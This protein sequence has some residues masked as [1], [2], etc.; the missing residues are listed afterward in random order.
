MN[1]A[2]APA[3][4]GKL[5][6]TLVGI[7]LFFFAGI[8]PTLSWIEFSNGIETLNV[9]TVLEMRRGGPWVV[10]TL[11]EK[12]RINKPPLTAWFT[13]T[14]VSPQ[15]VAALST[16]DPVARDDAY[17]QLAWEI[18]WP[19]LLL[20]CLTLGL[21][22][23]MGRL[24]AG[25]RIGV[26]AAFVAGSTF[27]FLRFGRLATLDVQL[28]FW[29]MLANVLLLHGLLRG[30][31]WLACTGSGFC[32]GMAFMAKGP[33]ALAMSVAP[34]VVASL[35]VR[36]WPRVERADDVALSD[37]PSI[38]RRL[39]IA[40]VVVGVVC[41]LAVA[42]P[43]F[44][45]VLNANPNIADAWRREVTRVGASNLEADPFYNHLGGPVYM[46][47][48]FIFFF[49]GLMMVGLSAWRGGRNAIILLSF[50]VVPII[51]L[52]FAKDKPIRYLQPLLAPASVLA[53][54]ALVGQLVPW[55]QRATIDRWLAIVHWVGLYI[56]V[57]AVPVA[58]VYFLK[59]F[60][61]EPWFSMSTAIISAVAGLV[62]LSVF[63]WLSR[64]NGSLIAVG[65]VVVML[66]VNA[67]VLVGYGRSQG[68][69]A[70][71]RPIADYL[72]ST[73]I[74]GVVVWRDGRTRPPPMDL[75]IYLNRV[76]PIVDSLDNAQRAVVMR[77]S[78]GT[79][80]AEIPNWMVEKSWETSP[81]RKW[82]L[83]RRTNDVT[84]V[85]ATGRS[86]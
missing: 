22:F 43:W 11:A 80:T 32:L 56:A 19:S 61:G 48:W 9:E 34:M 3:S 49:V 58:G 25:F 39:P 57:V 77:R 10:P 68:G 78:G 79:N 35:I 67:L 82:E 55:A 76:L 46:L 47:P 74:D 72:H 44:I 2:R 18:R 14:F 42:L 26:M 81:G 31:W 60:G 63:L 20:A 38:Q 73:S 17:R 23:E 64:R 12:Q 7:V 4:R 70:D 6:T 37:E 71:L 27:M 62:V 1:E 53:A 5:V 84:T 65:T 86:R 69:R 28:S 30:R 13:A 29:V 66:A 16:T 85:P 45:Y 52:S 54:V 41:L 21:T 40:A 8:A 24:L 33:V 59:T 51:I 75:F 50:I 15:T 36:W 83:L